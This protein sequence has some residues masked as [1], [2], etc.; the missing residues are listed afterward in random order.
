MKKTVEITKEFA[1]SLETFT[2]I[3]AEAMYYETQYNFAVREEQRSHAARYN[4]FLLAEARKELRKQED[5]LYSEYGG[6]ENEDA[7]VEAEESFEEIIKA[8]RHEACK[9]AEL[10]RKINGIE[11]KWE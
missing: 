6:A 7:Y 5:A 4:T 3:L 11:L 8:A 2:K 9:R 10:M 1:T